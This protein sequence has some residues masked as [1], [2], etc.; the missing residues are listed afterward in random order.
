MRLVIREDG[1]RQ[2]LRIIDT[3]RDVDEINQDAKKAPPVITPFEAIKLPDGKTGLLIDWVEGHIP[4]SS[5]E[6]ALCLTHAEELLRVPI[7][8]YDLWGGNFLVAE[9][10]DGGKKIY[11]IDSDI[12]EAIAKGGYEEVTGSRRE[13]FGQGKKKM[14]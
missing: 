11:N 10:F 1:R 4:T 13:L 5:E 8:S 6:E 2:V 7:D 3:D 12:P 14:K 9:N